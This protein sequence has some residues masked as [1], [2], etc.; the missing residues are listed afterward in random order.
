MKNKVDTFSLNGT[1]AP[2]MQ[3]S[4]RFFFGYYFYGSQSWLPLV[5]LK[6]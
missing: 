2:N 6:K 5:A 1:I 4:R 3:Q